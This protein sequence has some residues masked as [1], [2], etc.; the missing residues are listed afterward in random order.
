MGTLTTYDDLLARVCGLITTSDTIPIIGIN[1]HG[2]AGKATR[3][4]VDLVPTAAG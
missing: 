3:D 4:R 2:G 1:G